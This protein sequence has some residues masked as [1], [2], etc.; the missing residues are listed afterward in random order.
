MTTENETCEDCGKTKDNHF[1]I[2]NYCYE[3]EFEDYQNLEPTFKP[4]KTTA[5]LFLDAERTYQ[6]SRHTNKIVIQGKPQ[7]QS[8]CEHEKS[9]YCHTCYMRKWLNTEEGKNV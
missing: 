4:Q 5:D 1:S 8:L 7:N 6:E 9:G 2:V 3:A